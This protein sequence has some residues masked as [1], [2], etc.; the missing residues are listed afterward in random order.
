MIK[1]KLINILKI[2][3]E[4]AINNYTKEGWGIGI[5]VRNVGHETDKR[6]T[7]AEM[8][9][10]HFL[11]KQALIQNKSIFPQVLLNS[12]LTRQDCFHSKKTC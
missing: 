8:C 3:K 11:V 12:F 6:S 4:A 9:G 7:V 5:A 2:L 1:F 10:G